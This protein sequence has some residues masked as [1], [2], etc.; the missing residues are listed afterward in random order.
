[1]ARTD[2]GSGIYKIVSER[3]L[4]EIYKNASTG[5][6][7]LRKKPDPIAEFYLAGDSK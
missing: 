1:M 7:I 4:D 3:K 2:Q 5:V 6:T